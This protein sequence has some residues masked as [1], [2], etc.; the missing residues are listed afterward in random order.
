MAARVVIPELAVQAG[1]VRALKDVIDE[2]GRIVGDGPAGARI[3]KAREFA[4][5][6]LTATRTRN[7]HVAM[8]SM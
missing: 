6:P 4:G 1:R 2:R 5:I 7:T 3:S 8:A